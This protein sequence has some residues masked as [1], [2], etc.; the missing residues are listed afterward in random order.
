MRGVAK[1]PSVETL[2]ANLP[3]D[4]GVGVPIQVRWEGNSLIRRR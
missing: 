1:S 4:A 2:I 3:F